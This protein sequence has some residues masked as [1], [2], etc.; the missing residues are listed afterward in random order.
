MK[1][2]IKEKEHIGMIL[3]DMQNQV[4]IAKGYLELL[5]RYRIKEV[6]VD[7]SVLRALRSVESI[8][9]RIEE[10]D[11]YMEYPFK[12]DRLKANILNIRTIISKVQYNLE[13][14]QKFKH[15]NIEIT[16][17]LIKNKEEI[18]GDESLLVSSIEIVLISQQA[19]ISIVIKDKGLGIPKQELDRVFSP[20]FRGSNIQNTTNGKGKGIFYSKQIIEQ[21]SG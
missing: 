6:D 8:N 10:L 21:H 7:K 17:K 18:R 20:T 4:N 14:F 1:T 16:D 5:E 9:T 15:I 12:P 13:P 11:R 19:K 2:S 3:H